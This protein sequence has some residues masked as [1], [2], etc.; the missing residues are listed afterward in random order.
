MLN[1]KINSSPLVLLVDQVSL[2]LLLLVGSLRAHSSA[3]LLVLLLLSLDKGWDLSD[4]VVSG[5]RL[6]LPGHC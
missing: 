2:G 4:H 1:A 5:A 6:D 3:E